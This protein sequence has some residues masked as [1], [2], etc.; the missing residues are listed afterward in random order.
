MA[1]AALAPTA[2]T[3]LYAGFTQNNRTAETIQQHVESYMALEQLVCMDIW[4]Y[5]AATLESLQS[6]KCKSIFK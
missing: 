1:A 2:L 5:G 6:S 4:N 3:L